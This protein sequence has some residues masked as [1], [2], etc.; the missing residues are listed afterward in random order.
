M[1]DLIIPPQ[2]FKRF[3]RFEAIIK[4]AAGLFNSI[5]SFED[6]ETYLPGLVAE[7]LPSDGSLIHQAGFIHRKYGHAGRVFGVGA[8]ARFERYGTSLSV[9]GEVAGFKLIHR[10]LVGEDN[11]LRI[12]LPTKLETDRGLTHVAVAYENTMLIEDSLAICSAENKAGLPDRGENRIAVRIAN[13]MSQGRVGCLGLGQGS[14]GLV[15][16]GNLSFRRLGRRHACGYR[17]DDG[18]HKKSPFHKF[19]LSEIPEI[20]AA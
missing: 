19:F 18:Y 5:N 17:K 15:L 14:V 1:N 11:D 6:V 12:G 7:L 9:K 8:S 4:Q 16:D 20:P 2:L 13:K 10:L 3:P